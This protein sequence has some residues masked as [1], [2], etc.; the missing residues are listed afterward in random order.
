[1][2]ASTSNQ[3]IDTDFDVTIDGRGV[4]K[5]SRLE[6]LI[7]EGGPLLELKSSNGSIRLK[8]MGMGES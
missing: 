4:R 3:P 2:K 7:G 8:K 5:K 1:M 6:G